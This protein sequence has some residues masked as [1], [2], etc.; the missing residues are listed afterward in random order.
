MFFYFSNYLFKKTLTEYIS[1]KTLIIGLGLI[2]G[3]MAKALRQFT[4]SQQIDGID[5]DAEVCDL[6][7]KEKI[8]NQAITLNDD[9][10]S[11]DLIVLATPLNNFAEIINLISS[12]ISP[13]ATIFD[14]GSVKNLKKITV[15]KNFVW[16][17]PIA[18]SHH[19]G[20]KYSEG[21]LFAEKKF[22]ICSDEKNS[23]TQKIFSLAQK[24]K[25]LPDYI[26]AKLHDEIYGLVSHLPQF[27]AFLTRNLHDIEFQH[28]FFKRCFRLSN[29]SEQIWQDIF[30]LNQENL[31]NFY[32][33]FFDN[34]IYQ[35]ENLR[36]FKI[37]SLALKSEFSGII[38][39]SFIQDKILIKEFAENFAIILFNFLIVLSYLKIT[40]IK[41]YQQHA[42]SGFKDFT[43][44]INL[45]KISPEIFEKLL[46][47]N[48]NKIYNLFDQI[49]T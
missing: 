22:W 30:I 41:D 16:C 31:E 2:G 10:K 38:D 21:N 33:E 26:D 47:K 17:H 48:L 42:G 44:L 9:L 6:A 29:S 28:D 49:S 12:K 4:A 15:P 24:I 7:I 45:F 14:V 36:N 5:N 39:N 3:S 34:L 13:D 23:H 1:N 18:G 25:A 11:Y 35:I 37:D 40:K 43:A 46:A 27:L 32:H 19:Q 8:I 20:I